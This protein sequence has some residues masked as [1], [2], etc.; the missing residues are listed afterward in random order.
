MIKGYKDA[1]RGKKIKINPDIIVNA[2]YDYQIAY[3][4]T[5][6]MLTRFPAI[7][8]LFIGGVEM[9]PACLKAVKNA[10]LQVPT[11]ISILCYID[12]EIMPVLEPP[13]S[14]IRWPFRAMGKRA[15]ELL[16]EGP[17]EKQSVLFEPE[18]VIRGSTSGR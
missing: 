2:D 15:A 4:K 10:G 14:A 13:L 18:L 12:D 9:A 6:A 17:R 16:M 1:L 7:T 8:A 3:D 11:D 5:Q